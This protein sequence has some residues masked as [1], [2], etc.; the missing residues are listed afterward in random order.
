MCQ[1]LPKSVPSTPRTRACPDFV[2]NWR[3]KLFAK[4]SPMESLRRLVLRTRARAGAYC[5]SSAQLRI[6]GTWLE[7][8]AQANPSASGEDK[9]TPTT[10]GKANRGADE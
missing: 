5:V 4:A 8:L 3:A 6:Q 2:P 7:L 10:K 1:R 9:L